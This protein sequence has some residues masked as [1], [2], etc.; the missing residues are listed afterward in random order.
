MAF[1]RAR[2]IR[3]LGRSK[4]EAHDH[5]LVLSL[6]FQLLYRI[7]RCAGRAPYSRSKEAVIG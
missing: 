6:L 1:T 3:A 7:V 5:I 2:L 4:V